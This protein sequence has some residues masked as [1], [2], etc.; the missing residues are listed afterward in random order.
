M[1]LYTYTMKTSLVATR[2]FLLSADSTM[3]QVNFWCRHFVVTGC[4]QDLKEAQQ[5]RVLYNT[6]SVGHLHATKNNSS[7]QKHLKIVVII[8]ISLSLLT[9]QV[10]HSLKKHLIAF[11]D[12]TLLVGRQEGHPACKNWVVGCWHGYLS[13]GSCRLALCPSWCHC[14]SLSLASVKSR[15]VFTFLVPDHL[16][17]PGKRA[18]KRV[19]VKKHLI[20]LHNCKSATIL[21][22]WNQSGHC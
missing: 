15:L 3:K 17:S 12:L 22:T 20:R 4:T 9:E 2:E 6:Y 19:C 1:K 16:V 10:I 8:G 18:V 7:W 21:M 11:S 14:H 5:Q 13:G